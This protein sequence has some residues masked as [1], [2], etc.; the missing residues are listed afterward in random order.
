[1]KTAYWIQNTRLFRA[2]E[3]TCSKCGGSCK[4]PSE[5][6]PKM[7]LQNEKRKYDTSW[8]DEA[9]GLSAILDD[10]W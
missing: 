4:K 6:C 10:D 3:Y 5:Y 9:E 7:S 1:M 2:D 8:A